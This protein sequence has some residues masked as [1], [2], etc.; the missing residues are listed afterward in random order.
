MINIIRHC[1]E[2]RRSVAKADGEAIQ[3]LS[4]RLYD[5]IRFIIGNQTPSFDGVTRNGCTLCS[6]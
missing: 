2:S 5:G 6:Q 3:K 4:C 1:E